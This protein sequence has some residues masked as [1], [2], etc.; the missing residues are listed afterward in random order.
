MDATQTNN[1]VVI[2]ANRAGATVAVNGENKCIGWTDLRE[3]SHQYD[4]ELRRV[5]QQIL[6]QAE[7]MVAGGPVVV[8]VRKNSTNVMWECVVYSAISSGTASYTR[9]C[10]EGMEHPQQWLAAVE[11][12]DICDRLGTRVER[13]IGFDSTKARAQNARFEAEWSS[14]R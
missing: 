9:R 8:E 4:D 1:I 7:A 6:H 13:R 5:Y 10:D 14:R 12:A 3:A 2:G 11:A